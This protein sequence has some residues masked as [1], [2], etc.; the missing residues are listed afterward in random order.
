[1]CIDDGSKCWWSLGEGVLVENHKI[2]LVKRVDSVINLDTY[3]QDI[4]ITEL[5][6]LEVMGP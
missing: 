1:M 5:F 4:I 3:Y 2:E 6:S